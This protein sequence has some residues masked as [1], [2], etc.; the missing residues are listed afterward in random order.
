MFWTHLSQN[1]HG[2]RV[3]I[4]KY[5][6]QHVDWKSKKS[7]FHFVKDKDKEEAF[8]YKTNNKIPIVNDILDAYNSRRDQQCWTFWHL[9]L[10]VHLKS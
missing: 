5:Y 9:F 2:F 6:V 8:W 3:Q 1:K 7:R 10:S 4:C